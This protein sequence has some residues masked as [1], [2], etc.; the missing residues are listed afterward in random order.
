M[1]RAQ[2]ARVVQDA[3]LAGVNAEKEMLRE[4]FQLKAITKEAFVLD[5]QALMK[6]I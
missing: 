4:H 1:Q 5:M 3:R 2:V 6:K